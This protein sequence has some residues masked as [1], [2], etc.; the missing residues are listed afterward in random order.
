MHHGVRAMSGNGSLDLLAIR[1]FAFNEMR[2]GINGASMAFTQI[3]ENGNFMPLIQQKLRANAPDIAGAAHDKDFHWREE[4]S[5]IGGKSKATRQR[6]LFVRG[7][8]SRV[9]SL[10]PNCAGEYLARRFCPSCSQELRPSSGRN[11]VCNAERGLSNFLPPNPI[12]KCR[13]RHSGHPS[14]LRPI[15]CS[16]KD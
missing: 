12:A 14:S 3:I 9:A 7:C 1:K 5:V 16:Y 10:K 11:G 6:C 2:P 15:G 13:G 8:L 4:C